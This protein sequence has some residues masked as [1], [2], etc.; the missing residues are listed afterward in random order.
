MQETGRAQGAAA[1][2]ITVDIA[3]IMGTEIIIRM[4]TM[5]DILQI[6]MAILIG[7]EIIIQEARYMS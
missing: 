3:L 4:K 6:P 2:K 1:I 7:R 5:A